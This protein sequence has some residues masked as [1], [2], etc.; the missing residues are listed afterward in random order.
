MAKFAEQRVRQAYD[1]FAQPARLLF[2]ASW[3]PVLLIAT[4]RRPSIIPALLGV[5][6][7]VAEIGRR[8]HRGR[9]AF[10]ASSAGWAPLWVLER[11]VTVWIA[12]GARLRGG[13]RYR[14]ERLR[15]AATRPAGAARTATAIHPSAATWPEGNAQGPNTDPRPVTVV[16]SQ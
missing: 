11:A 12:I 2:E 15:T 3:L 7:L 4:L 10:P 9:A 13:A 8:R 5:P 14:G 1:D 16:G 6:I